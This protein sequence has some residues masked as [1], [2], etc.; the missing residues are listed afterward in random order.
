MYFSISLS[1]LARGFIYVYIPLELPN[2]LSFFN[3]SSRLRNSHLDKLSI[4]SCVE[5][6]TNPYNIDSNINRKSFAN[7][8]FY[9]AHIL[10]RDPRSF[11]AG[12]ISYLLRNPKK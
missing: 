2:H 7:S 6:R 3:G 9:R 10:F 8:F 1:A 4:V 11:V 12:V 5:P